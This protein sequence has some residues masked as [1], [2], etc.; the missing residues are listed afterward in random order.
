MTQVRI[1]DH[2]LVSPSTLANNAV[3]VASSKI[4]GAQENRIKITK[5]SMSVSATLRT[6]GEGPLQFGIANSDLTAAEIAEVLTSDPQSPNDTIEVE[7]SMR[8][9]FLMGMLKPNILLDS[10]WNGR[11]VRYP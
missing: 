8:E 4:D 7:H 11:N 9:V 3:A 6:T 2:V 5:M 10:E 1:Y